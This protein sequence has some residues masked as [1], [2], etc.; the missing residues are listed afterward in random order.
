MMTNAIVN[1]S[2]SETVV[3]EL[4]VGERRS[5]LT[6]AALC[7]DELCRRHCWWGHWRG[8]SSWCPGVPPGCRALVMALLWLQSPEEAD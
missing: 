3:I 6:A 5:E 1:C 4:V 8:H 7:R 2:T